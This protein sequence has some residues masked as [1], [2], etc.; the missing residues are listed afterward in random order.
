MTVKYFHRDCLSS[1]Q[2]Q[3]LIIGHETSVSQPF[4]ASLHTWSAISKFDGTNSAKIGLKINN[5][6][7]WMHL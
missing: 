6:D 7:N 5:C 3:K 2:S 1:T 4:I